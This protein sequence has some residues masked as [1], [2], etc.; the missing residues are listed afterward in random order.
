V[1][2]VRQ[3]PAALNDGHP[4]SAGQ[5]PSSLRAFVQ[6]LGRIADQ[7][8]GDLKTEL[9]YLQEAFK[10]QLKKATPNEHVFE[11]KYGV[12]SRCAGI[13]LSGIG[14]HVGLWPLFAARCGP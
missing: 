14:R 2:H 5:S 6:R 3:T 4:Q 11:E 12:S 1:L 13:G 10:R 7:K 8:R 9:K